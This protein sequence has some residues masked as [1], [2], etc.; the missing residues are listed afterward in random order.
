MFLA[1]STT[2]TTEKVGVVTTTPL[3]TT[4][5]VFTTTGEKT[6]HCRLMINCVLFET[7]IVCVYLDGTFFDERLQK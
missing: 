4:T 1:T 5:P 2:Q 3:E 6:F 7:S